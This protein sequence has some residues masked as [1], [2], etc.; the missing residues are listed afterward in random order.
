MVVMEEKTPI[1]DFRAKYL[2]GSR[3]NSFTLILTGV[4]CLVAGFFLGGSIMPFMKFKPPQDVYNPNAEKSKSALM[5][6]IGSQNIMAT[7]TDN[8]P[9]IQTGLSVEQI[10]NEYQLRGTKAGLLPHLEL[11]KLEDGSIEA[12]LSFLEPDKHQEKL[13]LIKSAKNFPRSIVLNFTSSTSPGSVILSKVR[14]DGLERKPAANFIDLVSMGGNPPQLAEG[15]YLTQNGIFEI[16]STA[17][18]SIAVIDNKQVYPKPEA[19]LQVSVGNS[20]PNIPN[21]P[22]VL[23]IVGVGPNDGVFK[24]R[25]ILVANNVKV[26]ECTSQA[27]I[28]DIPNAKTQVLDYML[29]APE[30]KID[31]AQNSFIL[32]GFCDTA[33]TSGVSKY[34]LQAK[35]NLLNGEVTYDRG[36][37]VSANLDSNI[38]KIGGS[39]SQS[40]GM[41]RATSPTRIASP[42]G[43]GNSMVSLACRPGGGVSISV[44]G[45]PAP[46]DGMGARINFGSSNANESASMRYIASANSYELAQIQNPD[47]AKAVL[48]VLR[49]QNNMI[50]SGLGRKYSVSTPGSTIIDSMLSKCTAYEAPPT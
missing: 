35:Y 14:V 19:S 36:L 47:A 29:K 3:L 40:G 4:I 37:S 41:W 7:P 33:N 44:S 16:K 32:S 49:S 23:R 12:S 42:I 1:A 30:V 17:N 25:F 18:G 43:E 6:S 10:L 22:Q 8:Q 13:A 27:V 38:V 5:V 39:T 15:Q 26:S 11:A 45:L 48:R 2:S 9:P 28:I 21:A 46:A 20:G 50:V 31:N 34:P 24:E